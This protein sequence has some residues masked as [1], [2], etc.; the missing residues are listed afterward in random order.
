MVKFSRLAPNLQVCFFLLHSVKEVK[1][2]FLRLI[3]LI[4]LLSNRN[5]NLI[6][7]VIFISNE[8]QN[9]HWRIF[10]F[11][12]K[13]LIAAFKCKKKVHKIPDILDFPFLFKKYDKVLHCVFSCLSFDFLKTSFCTIQR[14]ENLP[15]FFKQSHV[16]NKTQLS[17]AE[18]QTK[19]YY[20]CFIDRKIRT[21]LKSICKY[22]KNRPTISSF[23]FFSI[24]KVLS[25]DKVDHSQCLYTT[26]FFK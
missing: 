21:E 9:L 7:I 20:S 22:S 11:N 6:A 5:G 18:N 10:L 4:T 17:T 13:D 25:A 8:N 2:R 24:L 16:M 26:P 14:E 15:K 3:V 19:E 12:R 23:F 1:D